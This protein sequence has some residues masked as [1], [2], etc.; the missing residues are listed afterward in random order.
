MN[1]RGGGDVE[2]RLYNPDIPG[3]RSGNMSSRDLEKMKSAYDLTPFDKYMQLTGLKQNKMTKKVAEVN[4]NYLRM[5]QPKNLSGPDNAP[6][7]LDDTIDPN[8]RSA[9]DR[10]KS[11]NP[12]VQ[13]YDYVNG[14]EGY[15]FH[16][17][18]S[19]MTVH[20]STALINQARMSYASRMVSYGDLPA[21]ENNPASRLENLN[22]QAAL[23]KIEDDR[24]KREAERYQSFIDTF[25]LP[26]T[27]AP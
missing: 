23:K 17:P 16:I 24:M 11:L 4:G 19:A 10:V 25:D 6:F 3:D 15:N 8:A 27:A 14:A 7:Y 2:G 1:Q 21:M 20:D 5:P 22:A 18:M 9:R 12:L 26:D 13:P